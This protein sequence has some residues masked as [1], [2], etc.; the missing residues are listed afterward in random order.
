M[1]RDIQTTQ[2]IALEDVRASI[3]D[4]ELWAEVI[5]VFLDFLHLGE[6]VFI[7]CSVVDGFVS[8][9]GFGGDMI[10]REDSMVVEVND[11]D[12]V[13]FQVVA[14]MSVALVGI[15]IDDHDPSLG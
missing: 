11:E 8:S 12:L 3:V 2:R 1:L 14:F 7:G 9:D 10:P 4:D 5:H 13:V 15:Q 6:V